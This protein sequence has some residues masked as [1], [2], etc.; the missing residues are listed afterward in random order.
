[1][2]NVILVDEL[3]NEL[4]QMEKME[5]HQKG[6]LHRAFS[7]FLF[8]D[9]NQ[10]LLQQRATKKYHSGGLW[11]NT[12]C[13]HP[14]QGE[15][16]I[17]AGKRRLMEEMGITAEL[18]KQFSFIYRAEFDNGLIEHE[19]DHVM[20]GEYNGLVP[21]NKEEIMAVRYVDLEQINRELIEQPEI[22]TAWFKILFNQT[23]GLITPR[24]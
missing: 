6:E 3:D 19:L 15:G 5:A 8:N 1:M 11:S 7:V 16:I 17:E 21:F 9:K 20:F 4:G 13:S 12:C 24:K 10:L 14:R 18:I 23:K 2:E 22:Y